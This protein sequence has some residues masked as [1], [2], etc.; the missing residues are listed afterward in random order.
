M[1]TQSKLF[2]AGL[3]ITLLVGGLHA[4][5]WGQVPGAGRVGPLSGGVEG[6]QG[7]DSMGLKGRIICVGCSR[8]D[9]RKNQPNLL[10]LYEFTREQEH[11]V[12]KIDEASTAA[13]WEAIAGLSHQITVRVQDKV[14]Q[15]LTS[16]DNLFKQI[17]MIGI[18]SSSRTFDVARVKISGITVSTGDAVLAEPKPKS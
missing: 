9:V 8:D 10:N 16:E 5:V 13:R 18:L 15:Q 6:S 7:E 1:M 4:S 17:E 12:I 2:I 3:G 11:M 14:W